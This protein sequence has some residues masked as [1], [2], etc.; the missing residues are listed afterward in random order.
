MSATNT[1]PT[2]VAL[3]LP[4]YELRLLEKV[5][6]QNAKLLQGMN[7]TVWLSEAEAA[8]RVKVSVSTLRKWRTNG[9]LRFRKIEKVV[10]F[11]AA[12]IDE[13]INHR[14]LVNGSRLPQAPQT[15]RS[16]A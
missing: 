12:E 4:E 2:M 3:G 14:G 5:Y 6:E 15:Y 8:E 9:W 10:L 16:K 7:G 1:N 11:S 13:D